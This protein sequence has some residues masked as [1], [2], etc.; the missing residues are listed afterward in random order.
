M[1]GIEA[2]ERAFSRIGMPTFVTAQYHHTHTN[3]NKI[4]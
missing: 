2:V 1:S 4:W 3:N